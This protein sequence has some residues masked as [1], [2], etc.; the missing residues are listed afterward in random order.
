MEVTVLDVTNP[1]TKPVL[2][3]HA[4]TVRRQAKLEVNQPFVIPHPGTQTGTVEVSLFQQ[5][6]S[7]T[8]PSDSTPEQFCNIPV[9]KPDGQSSKVQLRVRRGKA[10]DAGADKAKADD[11]MV[12]TRDYL[13]HHQLQQRIQS[14]IQDVLREQ[15][16][17]PYKYMLG[18]LRKAKDGT[19]MVAQDKVP[20]AVATKTEE[21]P[22][23]ELPPPLLTATEEAPKPGNNLVPH[24]P[25]GPKPGGP[26]RGSRATFSK[27]DSLEE[28]GF[29]QTEQQ[30]KEKGKALEAARFSVMNL[31]RMPMCVTAAEKSLRNSARS[32]SASMMSGLVMNS[33]REK[34]LAEVS[35]SKIKADNRSLARTSVSMVISTASTFLSPEYHRAINSWARHLAYRS[36]ARRGDEAGD[37]R[38]RSSLPSPIVFLQGSSA[39]WGSWLGS[40]PAK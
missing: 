28:E 25:A 20:A 37:Q 21:K 5:L 22:G 19:G 18:Q 34:L 9:I 8:L 36:A 7:H 31:L 33:V 40:S 2:A 29:E 14:L 4:G 11:S 32:S 12:L 38:R 17:N 26:G 23:L 27:S 39:S 13:D 30:R 15:P 10:I 16:E 3:I 35:P 24:A 6:A 1:P